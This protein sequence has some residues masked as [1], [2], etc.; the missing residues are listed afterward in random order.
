MKYLLRTT[1]FF[2]FTIIPAVAFAEQSP[3]DP[4]N[5]TS[6]LKILS[7]YSLW[8]T[9]RKNEMDLLSANARISMYYRY[10]NVFGTFG[11][12]AESPTDPFISSTTSSSAT[13]TNSST[14]NGS[15]NLFQVRRAN[16]GFDLYTSDPATISFT[17]GRDRIVS[18]F[19]YAPD[20]IFQVLA[21]NSDNVSPATGFDGVSLKYAGTFEFGKVATGVG[22]Y[23]NLAVMIQSTGATWFGNTSVIAGDNSFNA[24]PKT[25]SRAVQ[26]FISADINAGAG[27]IEFKSGYGAQINAVT[28]VTTVNS[29][30]TYTARDVNSLES[31]VSYNYMNGIVKGGVWGQSVTLGK[32]QTAPFA[33]TNNLSYSTSATDDS[34]IINTVG[35]GVI[36]NS[37]LWGMTNLLYDGD[38]LR[39]GLAYQ[40]ATGQLVS[41]GGGTTGLTVFTNATLTTD[42][43]NV[44]VGYQQGNFFLELNYATLNANQQVYLGNDGNINQSSVSTFYLVGNLAF[45]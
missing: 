19:V 41:G 34:Q 1:L 14:T 23:N 10:K 5:F 8:D 4:A 26:S 27:I 7:R 20:A 24:A 12:L 16:I 2:V 39:Y 45:N 9:Y 11:F 33:V 31:S 25:Q 18:S 35:V 38:M 40:N 17:M 22:F 29:V 28:K 30:T 13:S 6:L 43:Y 44:G 15:Q 3:T 36:G 37:K 32:S 42:I 21:T